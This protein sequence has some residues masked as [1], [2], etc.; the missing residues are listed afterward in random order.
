MCGIFGYL[1]YQHPRTI[2]ELLTLLITGLKRLEYRGYD[3]AGLAIDLGSS[4]QLFKMVGNVDNLDKL[5]STSLLDGTEI[6]NCSS[7]IAHTRWATHG[8]PSFENCHPLS[9]NSTNDF[10]VVHNGIITNYNPLKAVL[11]KRGYTFT[12]ETD[13]EVVVKLVQYYWEE[14]PN[15]SFDILIHSVVKHLEGAY[16]FVFQSRHF[17]NEII[18]IKRGSPLIFGKKSN[19]FFLA[20]DISALIEHTSKICYLEDGDL[21]HIQGENYKIYSYEKDISRNFTT[22]DAEVYS[23]LKGN[24]DSFMLKEIH[25]QPESITNTMRGRVLFE[26]HKIQLGGIR[27][28]LK[29]IRR[30]RRIIFIACGTSYHSA[31]STRQLVE[32]LTELP[33]TVELASDFV[34]RQTPIFRDDTCIFISQSG[35]T[36]DT[37]LALNY[38]LESGALCVGITNTVGSSIARLTT[39]GVHV[40]AG[41]EIGVAST[42][43]YT[44]QFIVIIMIA[45]YI[46]SDKLSKVERCSQIIEALHFLPDKISETLLIENKIIELCQSLVLTKSM[47]ILGRG[48][49]YGTALEAA[50][51]I[52]EITYLHSEGIL[53]GELKH[54]P[55]ALVDENQVIFIMATR[56]LLFSKVENTV[57]QI[58]SRKGNPILIVHSNDTTF[59]KLELPCIQIP[60]T[61]DCLQGILNIIPFQLISYHLAVRKG[62]NV[63]QPRNL[64]KS[65]TV[66]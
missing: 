35:E 54:G 56:D 66:E 39:C 57:Q 38:C 8:I 22:L 26:K 13:T 19:E 33:V 49:Q 2:K 62:L 16:A 23:L 32:E 31:V 45:M 61:I 48:F 11:L 12:S 51:K 7:G 21:I 1:A 36:A 14:S 5:V 28:Q 4:F 55:L 47:L 17:P 41:I 44:S 53:S 64:A 9:S 37:L 60:K 42:K 52:K 6:L 50:L 15:V 25:E 18:G 10:I 58:L 40:N 43:A 30:C 63:D 3:S 29:N 20:S 24:Y 65:V 27:D 59:D 34:D 46:A